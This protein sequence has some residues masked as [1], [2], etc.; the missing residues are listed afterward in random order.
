VGNGWEQP[1]GEDWQITTSGAVSAI[2]NNW[3]EVLVRP[4]A[5]KFR[6]GKASITFIPTLDEAY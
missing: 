5:E 1:E 2:K 6:D 3:N 4:S